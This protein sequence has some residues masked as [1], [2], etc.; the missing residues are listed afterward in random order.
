MA[1][2]TGAT[3]SKF[4]ARRLTPVFH[5]ENCTQ[6]M[7]CIASCPDTALPNT[8]QDIGTILRTAA[9]NYVADAGQKKNLLGRR[10]R[11]RAAAARGHGRSGSSGEGHAGATGRRAGPA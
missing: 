5:A 11:D 6:C 10:G 2:A 4:V 1:A 3:S 8:A 9:Q 7:E